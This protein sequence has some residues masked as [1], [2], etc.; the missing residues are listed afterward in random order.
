MGVDARLYLNTRWGLD[1]IKDVI[2]RTQNTKVEIRSHHDFSPG[3]FSFDFKD[4]MMNVHTYSNFPT[5]QVTHLSLC[6]NPEGIK[7]L[8]D[9]A[10]VLGGV[11]MEQ[12]YDGKCELIDGAMTDDNALPYFVK[13]AIVNDGI[14][15]DDTEAFLESKQNWHKRIEESKNK[16]PF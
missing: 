4:R 3:Y 14:E 7:I 15:P 1:N 8:K 5:G 10:E 9:I 13:Y 11:L 12:D 16:S 2:E 6:S